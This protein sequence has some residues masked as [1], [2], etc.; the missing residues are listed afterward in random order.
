MFNNNQLESLIQALSRKSLKAN[1]F[2]EIYVNDV[3]ESN[4]KLKNKKIR[5]ILLSR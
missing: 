5:F 2:V 1:L 3:S 4:N